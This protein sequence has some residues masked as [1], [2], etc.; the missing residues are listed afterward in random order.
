MEMLRVVWHDICQNQTTAH[1]SASWHYVLDNCQLSAP[2]RACFIG[3]RLI[4]QTSAAKKTSL[5]KFRAYEVFCSSFV[6]LLVHMPLF[7]GSCQGLL[8][9]LRQETWHV[10]THRRCTEVKIVY[11]EKESLFEKLFNVNCYLTIFH[12]K[13]WL[14]SCYLLW[15]RKAERA[16]E[17][18]KMSF[19]NKVWMS[20]STKYRLANRQEFWWWYTDGCS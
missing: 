11:L 7:G 6:A 18:K 17:M 9:S 8:L 13:V 16:L 10:V 4:C 15:S 5:E 2:Q 14:Y 20:L 3:Q 1:T 19:K 12:L